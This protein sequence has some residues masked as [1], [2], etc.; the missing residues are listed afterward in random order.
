MKVKGSP[1]RKAVHS[2]QKENST[3]RNSLEGHRREDQKD[4]LVGI[5][6]MSECTGRRF[7]Q[8][9]REFGMI[10][11]LGL[12]PPPPH[13]LSLS[14][15]LS[16]CLSVFHN[17]KTHQKGRP[18]R[19]HHRE[20]FTS[21]DTMILDFPTELREINIYCLSHPCYSVLQ[22]QPKQTKTTPKIM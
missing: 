5:P 7:K 16:L 19:D 4:G 1:R 14:L 11:R 6:D 9:R 8:L 15:S 22:W 13:P 17:S 12:S 20:L 2:A 21:A 18:E 3:D 10:L